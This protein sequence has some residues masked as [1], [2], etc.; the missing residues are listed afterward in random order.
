MKERVGCVSQS[1]CTARSVT[2]SEGQGLQED[3]VFRRMLFRPLVQVGAR[4]LNCYIGT[5]GAMSARMFPVLPS[6]RD[7]AKKRI[8]GCFDVSLHSRLTERG[9]K[10][11]H[12]KVESFEEVRGKDVREEG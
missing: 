4:E 1:Q 7:V 5:H 12:R 6:R 2:F 10:L 8:W 3:L 11:F 9:V